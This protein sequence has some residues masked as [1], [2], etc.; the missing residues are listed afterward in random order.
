MTI[1]Q[2]KLKHHKE[3]KIRKKKMILC[4]NND[5]VIANACMRNQ[6]YQKK[7]TKLE[8]DGK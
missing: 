4:S 8:E 2:T 3:N 6:E 1:V 7:D 5:C